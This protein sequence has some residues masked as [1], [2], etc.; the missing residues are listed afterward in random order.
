MSPYNF[1]SWNGF[2]NVW[3]VN[4][5]GQLNAYNTTNTIGV[6]P[7]SNFIEIDNKNVVQ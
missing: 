4:S 1:E 7:D 6:R 5:T 3:I 2:A